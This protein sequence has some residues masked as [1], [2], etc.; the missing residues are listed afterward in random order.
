MSF[1]C[2]LS[3][4]TIY[5]LL[6]LTILVYD[7][8]ES[9]KLDNNETIENF[10]NNIDDK[11]TDLSE[12]NIK[13][14]KEIAKK[15]KYGKVEM[16]LDNPNT[17]LQ[18]GITTS[19]IN[20]RITLV[21][22]GTDSVIDWYH[23]LMIT[24]TEIEKDVWIHS[25]FYQQLHA[26][27][28]FDKIIN[29]LFLLMQE[30]ND[31]DV[32]IVG[33]SLG[34]ALATIA[35]YEISGMTNTNINVVTFGSPRVGNKLFQ[36]NCNNK[37]NL[38]IHRIT[39]NKDI[40]CACPMIGFKHVGINIDMTDTY[41]KKYIENEYPWWRYSLFWCNKASDH[42]LDKYLSTLIKWKW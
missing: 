15:S 37:E 4:S 24:K 34:S 7:Y 3:Y 2:D 5:D 6:I 40:I 32:Y 19:K 29:K 17:G 33:H 1:N 35:G 9:F 22:R 10:V 41:I 39:N 30:Y 31:Y 8:G 11:S 12:T 23:D 14:L 25:G 28:Y 20:K 18:C 26:D 42:Y 36:T 38:K 21:I 16:F 27:G 13:L